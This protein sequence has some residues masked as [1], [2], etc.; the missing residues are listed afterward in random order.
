MDQVKLSDDLMVAKEV[1]VVAGVSVGCTKS[2]CFTQLV[3]NSRRKDREVNKNVFILFVF[4]VC[5][6]YF[7]SKKCKGGWDIIRKRSVV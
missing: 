2:F 4:R 1:G 6:L 3:K 5:D 7:D